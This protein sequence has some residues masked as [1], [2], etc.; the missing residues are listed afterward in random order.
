MRRSCRWIGWAL[1]L[2]ASLAV[3]ARNDVGGDSVNDMFLDLVHE[4]GTEPETGTET[5]APFLRCNKVRR[6][7]VRIDLFDLVD[8]SVCANADSN[9]ARRF[10]FVLFFSPPLF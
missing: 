9:H 2:C 4:D 1:C 6:V 3:S 8:A 10:C 5:S 7:A